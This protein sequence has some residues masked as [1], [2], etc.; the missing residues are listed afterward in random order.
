MNLFLAAVGALVDL[1]HTRQIDELC[2]PTIGAVVSGE[3]LVESI[4]HGGDAEGS[5]EGLSNLAEDA[6]CEVTLVVCVAHVLVCLEFL[7]ED[8]VQ[9]ELIDDAV[10]AH[11]PLEQ[12]TD[13]LVFEGDGG[14][15]SVGFA[16]GDKVV[17]GHASVYL[18]VI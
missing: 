13:T 10:L 8:A 3:E 4:H 15:D 11:V 16:D 14:G 9:V 17:L 5:D 2:V 1:V 12:V 6:D 7:T 18:S